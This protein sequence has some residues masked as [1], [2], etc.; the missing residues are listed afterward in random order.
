MQRI[1]DLF[2]WFGRLLLAGVI[3]LMITFVIFLNKPSLFIDD[4]EEIT[5]VIINQNLN[6]D[7][8]INIDTIDGD[9]VSGFYAKNTS[10]YINNEVIA[11]LDSIYVN[12]NVSDLLFL[13]ISFSNF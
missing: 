11:S 6:S 5:S 7:L 8:N 12:P 3:I 1:F 4:I 13:K 2:K 9:F 10:I